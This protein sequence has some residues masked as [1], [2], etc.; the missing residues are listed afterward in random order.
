MLMA[1]DD[2]EKPEMA[3]GISEMIN[4]RTP[5]DGGGKKPPRSSARISA[6]TRSKVSA[7]QEAMNSVESWTGPGKASKADG[8]T[9]TLSLA[10]ETSQTAS[11]FV[12][13][14]ET[15]IRRWERVVYPTLLILFMV[16]GL[17]A[18]LIYE[19]SSDM[20]SIAR[21]FD[22]KMG[23]HM[24]RLTT[25]MERLS[26]NINV[27]TRH[28][29]TMSKNVD[30]MAKNTEIMTAKMRYLE[31]MEVIKTEMQ[32]MNKAMSFMTRDMG[33]MR[34]NVA[35]MNRSVSKPMS[36]FNSFMPW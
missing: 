18:F 36:F 17:A 14:M 33:L 16:F 9:G 19:L 22:P 28:V 1:Q 6:D 23:D 26:D 32:Q 34:H 5:D 12:G 25:Q 15:S 35:G 2:V 24:S 4:N 8:K 29:D 31:N 30:L 13:L 27:M 7:M 3:K 21:G 10:P 11:R 20:R